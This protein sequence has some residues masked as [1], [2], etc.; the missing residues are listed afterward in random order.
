MRL[1]Q[2]TGKTDPGNS[3]DMTF[4]DKWPSSCVENNIQN[5]LFYEEIW[6]QNAEEN[7]CRQLTLKIL[8][9]DCDSEQEMGN[10]IDLSWNPSTIWM[11]LAANLFSLSVPEFSPVR[12]GELLI[13]KHLKMKSESICKPLDT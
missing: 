6:R 9:S 2:W 5:P 11:I 12:N 4:S 1:A 3:R 8:P 7:D 13:L 10:R